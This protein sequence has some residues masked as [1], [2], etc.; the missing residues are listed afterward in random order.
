MEILLKVLS[1]FHQAYFVVDGLDECAD[2]K[3]FASLL[4]RIH[5]LSKPITKIIFFSRSDP[6][7][8]APFRRP[9]NHIII[10]AGLNRRDIELYT[11]IR[12]RDLDLADENIRAEIARNLVGRAEGM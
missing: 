12:L 2:Q 11:T 8:G 6:P 1:N 3:K 5:E 10:D 7:E 9:Y 4:F